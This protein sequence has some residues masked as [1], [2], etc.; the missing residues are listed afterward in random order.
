MKLSKMMLSALLVFQLSGCANLGD[1]QQSGAI[2]GGV[3]GGLLGS[4]FGKGSGRTAMAIGGSVV[5]GLI[6]TSLGKDMD[7]MNRMR[8]A[9]A[10]E[11]TPLERTRSWVDTRTQYRYSVKPLKT[12]HHQQR[13]CRKYQSSVLIEGRLHT[14]QG[15]A[16]RNAAGHWV[17]QN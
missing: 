10:L 7:E 8:F 16:C 4:Q 9:R 3:L 2:V 6:G 1:Q 13:L 12:Y 17:I 11:T 14:A 5:G 15:R